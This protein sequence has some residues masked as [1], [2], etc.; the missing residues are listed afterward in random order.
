MKTLNTHVNYTIWEAPY[1]LSLP[2][3]ISFQIPDDDPAR[4]VKLLIE[5]MDLSP[6]YHT[7]SRIK[8]NQ[9][10]PRQ[11]L[12]IVIYA[13]M[14]Q[15]FSSSRIESACRRDLNFQYLLEVKPAPQHAT[16]IILAMAHNV[17]TLHHK[18]QSGNFGTYLY[19]LKKVKRVLE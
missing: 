14:N 10:S 16:S 11:L 13:G 8:K 15:I 9:A 17:L 3:N 2:L 6:L 19:S 1:Q 4:L 7:Y 5:R 12:A 18:L